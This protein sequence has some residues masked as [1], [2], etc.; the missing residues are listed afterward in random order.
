M[1]AGKALQLVQRACIFEGLGV[2]LHGAECRVATGTS[3]GVLF[4]VRGVRG[5]V[6]AQEKP[7]TARGGRLDQSQAVGFA[8]EHGQTVVVRAHA[9]QKQ[10]IAVEQQMV[11]GDGGGGRAVG[12]G[13]KL[14]GLLGGDVFHH[15]FEFGEVAPK[16]YEVALNEH[17]LAVKQVHRRVGD[18]AMHQQ[19]QA[20]ALHGLQGGADFA[21]IGHARIAVGGGTGR[22]ELAS[23][24]TGVFGAL[25]LIGG[26]A[27]GEVQAHQR[28]KRRAFGQ[29]G[30]DALAIGQGQRGAGDGRLQVGHHQCTG[31]LRRGVGHHGLQGRAV[32]QMYMPVVG[33]GQAQGVGGGGGGV[34]AHIVPLAPGPK[35]LRRDLK[36][37]LGCARPSWPCAAKTPTA[38]GRRF[39]VWWRWRGPV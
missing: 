24:H 23:H 4:Q 3:T 18:F 34:H 10:G 36:P 39:W 25:D 11:G 8:L 31:K 2:H 19:Q 14:R 15:D 27:V 22:V 29:G 6:G 21:Q 16:G 30:H 17:R 28:V 33:L 35:T 20:M 26:Q 7:R 32:A 9:T 13:D 37:R 38:H 12:L 1:K 5:A